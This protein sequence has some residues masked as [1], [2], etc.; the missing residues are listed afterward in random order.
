MNGFIRDMRLRFGLQKGT[1]EN[2]AFPPQ[3]VRVEAMRFITTFPAEASVG[4]RLLNFLITRQN[5]ES[6]EQI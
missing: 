2:P 6:M 4:C 5:M 1:P 3:G